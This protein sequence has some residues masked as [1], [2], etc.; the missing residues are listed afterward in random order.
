[1]NWTTGR[2]AQGGSTLTQQLAKNLFLTP[3]RSLRRKAQEAVLALWLEWKFSKDELLEIYLNRVYLG[4]GAFGVDAAARLYLRRA[5]DAGHLWQ[6]AILAGLPKAPSRLN[7][8]TAPDAAA[9]PRGGGAGGHGRDRRADPQPGDAGQA[10]RSASRRAP[11][12]DA[13]WFADW[14]MDDLA[15][16]LPRQCRPGAAHHARPAAC[17]RWWRRGWRRCSPAPARAPGPAR[18]R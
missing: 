17:R 1:M 14:V 10:S 3:E 15:D 13:G 8:R 2:V 12:R 4:A 18:A 9:A 16:A 5:R 6:A 11:S 7:P